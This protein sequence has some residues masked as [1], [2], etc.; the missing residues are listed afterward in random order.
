MSPIRT[1]LFHL[2]GHPVLVWLLCLLGDFHLS[3][4]P[5]LW[6]EKRRKLSPRHA[7]GCSMH[8]LRVPSH[9]FLVLSSLF[10]QRDSQTLSTIRWKTK[11]SQPTKPKPL[12]PEDLNTT[13]Q[14]PEPQTRGPT[15]LGTTP[16]GPHPSGP[17]PS[18]PRPRPLPPLDPPSAG[19]PKIW[20]FF[21]S[22]VTIV[23]LTSSRGI[24]VVFLKRRDPEMCTFGVLGLSCLHTLRGTLRGPTHRGPTLPALRGST[25]GAPHFG[26]RAHTKD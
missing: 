9:V 14:R 10:S 13:T 26:E 17:R 22:P 23:F 18:G 15:L 6:R 21:P 19:P 1:V 8:A 5:E 3:R 16:S 25:L 4:V 7:C 11:F 12:N 24:L 20:L 2:P